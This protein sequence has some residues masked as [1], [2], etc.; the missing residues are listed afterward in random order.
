MSGNLLSNIGL[1]ELLPERLDSRWGRLEFTH[2][3]EHVKVELI[4]NTNV[5][6]YS[7][8]SVSSMHL[9]PKLESEGM[10]GVLEVAEGGRGSAMLTAA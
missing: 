10:A 7:L 2:A 3:T 8:W 9:E 5:C 4:G 6:S 1:L